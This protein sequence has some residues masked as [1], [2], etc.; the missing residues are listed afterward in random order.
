MIHR[1]SFRL[2]LLALILLTAVGIIILPVKGFFARSAPT[3]PGTIF[4]PLVVK[5]ASGLSTAP[6]PATAILDNFNTADGSP[7]TQ[8]SAQ[9]GG[10]AIRAQQLAAGSGGDLVWQAAAYGPDQEVSVTLNAWDPLTGEFGLLLKSQSPDGWSAGTLRVAYSS[11]NQRLEIA[12]YSPAQGWQSLTHALPAVFQAGDQFGARTTADG[13]LGIF[14]NGA[15]LAEFDLSK[16]EFHNQGGWIG[17][18]AANGSGAVL[19]DFAGGNL[20]DT[21]PPPSPTPIP[22]LTSTPG[23]GSSATPSATATLTRTSSPVPS[24]T[25]THTP[26]WTPTRTPTR[27]PTITHTPTRT[28]TLTHTPTRTL[29][30]TFTRTATLT[31][32]PTATRTA[33][34]THTP[35]ASPTATRTPTWTPSPSPVTP[36]PA[37]I[38]AFSIG[39]GGSD[40]IPHQI[41]RTRDDRLFIFGYG[42]DGSHTL[43]SY[44]TTRAGFPA[45]G[46]DFTSTSVTDPAVLISVETVYDGGDI[47]HV[48]T[49]STDGILRD[50]PFNITTH[51]F[52]A[53]KAIDSGL[54]TA[55]TNVG[56]SGVS[57]GMDASGRLHV[58]YWSANNHITYRAYTYNPA[59]DALAL[60]SGPTQLD[61]AGQS[62]HPSLAVSPLDGSVTVAWVSE[63]TDPAAILARTLAGTVWG[64]IE[65]VSAAPVWTSTNFGINIDQGPSLVIDAQGVR[66]LA[67]VEDFRLTAPFEYGRVHY[68]TRSATTWN[69]TYTGF[70]THDPAVAINSAGEV[71]IIGHGETFNTAPC[72]SVDD[73]CAYKRGPTGSWTAHLVA[74]H[75]AGRSFDTS[76]SVKWAAFGFNRPETIEFIFPEVIA[77]NYAN[78]NLFYGV[79]GS[80]P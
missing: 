80:I 56:T 37:G 69:D 9:T 24:G 49:N 66:H 7:G 3:G 73:M 45:S 54:I 14:R 11:P 67:Y 47:I 70:Y 26:T 57:A 29:T 15:L 61:T 76:P 65:G 78:S 1:L 79:I 20:T 10:Y 22:S 23:P 19:D 46:A 59:T 63:A 55:N 58:A 68:V 62:N 5:P 25:P 31:L 33:T 36:P 2:S 48:L 51:T 21:L 18:W 64:P 16:W 72:L 53:T 4:L 6:F 42:G 28:P 44:W 32:T 35:I 38:T 12:T 40:V 77:G 60:I 34:P 43:Y 75:Q 30:P 50:R 27:T 39:T 13:W 41:V 8:W 52:L 71:Y 74:T 17:L